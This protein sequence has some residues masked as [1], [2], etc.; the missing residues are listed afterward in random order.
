MRPRSPIPALLAALALAGC[1]S[2]Q[3]HGVVPDPAG[4]Y[5]I[6]LLP[7][8]VTAG[9]RHLSDLETVAPPAPEGTAERARIETALADAGAG[10]EADLRARLGASPR[11]DLVDA[12]TTARALAAAGLGTGEGADPAAV[13]R[14]AGADAALSVTLAGYGR[15]PGRWVG[16]LIGSGVVEG[17]AQGVIAQQVVGNFWVGLGVAAEEIASE[18]LTWG[19]AAWLFDAHYAPVA[20]E[21]RL[22]AAR[23]GRRVWFDLTVVGIDRKGL[24]GLPPERRSRREVQLDL[25]AAKAAGELAGHLERAAKRRLHPRPTSVRP[26]LPPGPGRGLHSLRGASPRR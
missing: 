8:T 23:D 14:A 17:V 3:A 6:V 19:G 9:A 20:L 10:L 25:T 13:A 21:A 11:L 2:W 15:I 16:Y 26:T 18:V 22:D 4:A 24:K 5:R 12:D 7:V 1:A